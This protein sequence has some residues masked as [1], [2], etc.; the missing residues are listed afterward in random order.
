M[1]LVDVMKPFWSFLERFFSVTITLGGFSFSVGAFFMWSFLL[2]V[3]VGFLKGMG[4]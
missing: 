3:L 1:D 2:V 4:D